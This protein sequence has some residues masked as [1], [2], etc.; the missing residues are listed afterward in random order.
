MIIVWLSNSLLQKS[1][2]EANCKSELQKSTAE[3]NCKSEL[4]KLTAEA[5]C[6][7]ELQKWTA[8]ANCKSELQK[9]TAEAQLNCKM[10]RKR[11]IEYRCILQG[12]RTLLK[13][14]LWW[15]YMLQSFNNV[16]YYYFILLTGI[17][18]SL[19][20]LLHI[21]IPL[22]A[23]KHRLPLNGEYNVVARTPENYCI[24][25]KTCNGDCTGYSCNVRL[26]RHYTI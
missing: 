17:I 22:E 3:A 26:Y 9:R 2:A 25:G 15:K 18:I 6:K 5:N 14:W 1:T 24:Y 13:G 8:E 19:D 20:S 21:Q 16:C 7:S 4:Q 12:H 11:K 10:N 23:K